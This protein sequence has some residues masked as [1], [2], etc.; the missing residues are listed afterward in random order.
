MIHL[1]TFLILSLSSFAYAQID[2]GFTPE[3]HRVYRANEEMAAFQKIPSHHSDPV[4]V[5]VNFANQ[6]YQEQ[7]VADASV[8]S[9][10]FLVKNAYASD[11][12]VTH[13][14]LR[15]IWNSFEVHYSLFN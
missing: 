12:G 5:A 3:I 13:V 4:A 1:T 8:P 2:P 6:Y 11:T 10:S 9:L 15:Q 14:Y 7:V